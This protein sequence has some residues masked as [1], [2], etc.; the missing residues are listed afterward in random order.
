MNLRKTSKILNLFSPQIN[1]INEILFKFIKKRIYTFI[2]ILNVIIYSQINEIK[3]NLKNTN[4]E[5]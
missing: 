3:K 2:V 5:L 1:N 4:I